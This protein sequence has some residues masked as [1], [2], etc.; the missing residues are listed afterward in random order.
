MLRSALT[1]PEILNSLARAGHG[2]R[3]LIADG[4]YPFS[5]GAN[6]A[7][8]RVYLN[9]TPGI[10]LATDVLKAVLTAIP[11][12]SAHVMVPQE[13]PEPPIFREFRELLGKE[14]PLQTLGRFEFYEAARGQ[15]T[16]L[17]IATG[18]QRV[19]ANVLLT[20]GVVPPPGK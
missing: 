15:D 14:I 20:I 11:V 16:A 3:V 8:D 17:V 18:E 19:F 5:T 12:E 6:P 4:N 7:A 13:G 9:L 2:S 10:P 1:H